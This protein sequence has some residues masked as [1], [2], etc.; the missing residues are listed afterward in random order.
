VGDP[1]ALS[2][3][4]RGTSRVMRTLARASALL[5]LTLG[6]LALTYPAGFAAIVGAM[7]TP[8]ALYFA[9]AIRFTVGVTFLL[10]APSSRATL[11]LFFLGVV[12]AA[13]GLVTPFIGQGLARPILDA[14]TN[15]GDGVVRGWGAAA[16]LLGS[17]ALWAL[18]PR[19]LG[20]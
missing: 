19:R 9:A 17:F 8:P 11:P 2:G 6:L 4:S 3:A 18:Q 20:G 13:G 16:V 1:G 14:W 10:A 5:I 15:G 7:Q 12:M